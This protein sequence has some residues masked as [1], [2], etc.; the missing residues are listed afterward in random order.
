MYLNHYIGKLF[1]GLAF[2]ICIINIL[3]VALKVSSKNQER[4]TF[5]TGIQKFLTIHHRQLGNVLIVAVIF[6]V[7]FLAQFA[8]LITWGYVGL[9]GLLT[10]F[11]S[12]KI[13]GK[14][15]KKTRAYIHISL[16]LFF[17]LVLTLHLREVII[18]SI[19][20]QI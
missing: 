4:Q 14:F 20:N 13:I 15:S 16:G 8:D 1:G 6:H 10:I 17:L 7:L 18:L 12:T 11:A 5:F 19:N 3:F 2:T 9:I